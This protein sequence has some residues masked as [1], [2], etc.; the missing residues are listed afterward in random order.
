MEDSICNG[1]KKYNRNFKESVNVLSIFHYRIK[2]NSLGNC[3]GD[4]FKLVLNMLR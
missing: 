1:Y 2:V 3:L 4:I